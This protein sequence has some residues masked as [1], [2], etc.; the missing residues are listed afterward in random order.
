ML[1]HQC[2]TI[3][4]LWFGLSRATGRTL[5]HTHLVNFSVS[6]VR[7]SPKVQKMGISRGKK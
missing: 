2:K 4:M 1:C 6:Y 3:R 5:C 7:F